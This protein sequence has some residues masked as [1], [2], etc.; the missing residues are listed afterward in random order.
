MDGGVLFYSISCSGAQ[1]GG[2]VPG[3]ISHQPKGATGLEKLLG[4]K[5]NVLKTHEC[6]IEG[7]LLK[8]VQL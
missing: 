8:G 5:G 4:W 7:G 2:V 3:G 1:Q 6:F